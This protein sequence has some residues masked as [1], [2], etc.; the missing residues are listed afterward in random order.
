MTIDQLSKLSDDE[1]RVMVAER[2]GWKMNDHPDCLAKTKGW[3]S[4]KWETWVMTPAGE[5][6]FRCDIP[7]YSTS[8]DAMH[9]AENTLDG[10][11]LDTR[12]KWLDLLAITCNWPKRKNSVELHF[13]VQYATARAT[14]RQ[15]AIAFLSV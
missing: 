6:V 2:L 1:L 9:E 5:L 4:E 7:P 8:L 11:D 14:A 10:C 3:I 12:S 13:E 15:R